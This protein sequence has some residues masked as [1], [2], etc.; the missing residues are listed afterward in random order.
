M[1]PEWHLD[2]ISTRMPRTAGQV[3]LYDAQRM[4]D[5]TSRLSGADQGAGDRRAR[6]VFIAAK[7]HDLRTP[8]SAIIR[9]S[10]ML[11]EDAEDDGLSWAE[12]LESILAAGKSLL[13]IVDETLAGDKSNP[14]R[15]TFRT[16]P[17]WVSRSV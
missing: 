14:A 2:S 11:L 3:S 7:R 9:Y 13:A 5:A 8:I 15:S 16:W 4:N 10:E 17:P 6:E 1:A 12:G